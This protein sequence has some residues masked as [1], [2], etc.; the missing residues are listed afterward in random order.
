MSVTITASA[1]TP[2]FTT[3][4]MVLGYETARE[5]GNRVHTLIDGAIA[6]VLTP[7]KPR[8]GTLRLF[9]PAEADAFEAL[10]LHA[11][12]ATFTL[13]GTDRTPVH[14]SYVVADGGRVALELDDTT[15]NAFVV[16]VDYQELVP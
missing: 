4:A 13:V 8:Q 9:Y 1:G 16:A 5:S 3:P 7:A 12:A 15:R 10:A 6:V 11:R 2:A 14:M